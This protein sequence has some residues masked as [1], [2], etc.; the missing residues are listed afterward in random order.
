MDGLKDAANSKNV[1]KFVFEEVIC[2]HRCHR[3]IVMDHGMDNL[4]LIKDLLEHYQIQ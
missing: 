4:N 1:S 2:R 3:H